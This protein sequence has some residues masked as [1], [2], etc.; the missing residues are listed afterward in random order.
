LDVPSLDVHDVIGSITALLN[1]SVSN[2]DGRRSTMERSKVL[3][4]AMPGQFADHCA[5]ALWPVRHLRHAD[6]CIQR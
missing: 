6:V 1:R 2:N 5:A 4:W 3:D